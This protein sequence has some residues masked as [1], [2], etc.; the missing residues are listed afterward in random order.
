MATRFLY[1]CGCKQTAVTY[2]MCQSI[3]DMQQWQTQCT[4]QNAKREKRLKN[5]TKSPTQ[6]QSLKHWR[7]S[8]RSSKQLRWPELRKKVWWR[9]HLASLTLSWGRCRRDAMM[10]RR[11]RLWRLEQSKE[12][13]KKLRRPR[14]REMRLETCSEKRMKETEDASKQVFTRPRVNATKTVISRRRLPSDKPN[15]PWK[16]SCMTKDFLTRLQ[17]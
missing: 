16:M 13:K 14:G 15:Q 12:G 17:A 8:I 7:K 10:R 3:Q 1:T 5:A 4:Q 9:V 6:S 2:R 11:R